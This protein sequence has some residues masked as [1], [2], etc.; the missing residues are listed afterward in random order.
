[1]V[2]RLWHYHFG[3]GLVATPSDFGFGGGLPS[4]PELLDYL[5]CEFMASGWRPKAIHRLIMLSSTYRQSSRH[6]S[7]AAAVDADNRLLW[8]F[9][10]R[11][12]EAEALRDNILAASG[13]LDLRMGGPGYDAFEPNTNYVKVYKPKEVFGPAEWRRMI[14]QEKPRLQSDAT[15]GAFDCPD[16]SQQVAK[17]NTSTTALQAL[18]FLNGPFMLQQSELFAARL[19]REAADLDARIVLA[20]RLAFSRSPD[21]DE[22]AA[23]KKLV[24]E[25]G[26]PVF[27]R[28]LF[29]A[30]EFLYVN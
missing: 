13:T 10:P 16:A 23:A 12:L 4:H 21:G 11:R 27:C 17:R 25:A 28:A 2:N 30:N 8:R 26:L 15:F 7:R 14:Y 9:A 5:A 1:M 18:N 22:L 3:R 19:E 6:D 29:N 20:F 24:S